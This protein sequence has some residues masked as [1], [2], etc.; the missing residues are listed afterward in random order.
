MAQ[1]KGLKRSSRRTTDAGRF[2]FSIPDFWMDFTIRTSRLDNRYWIVYFK[3]L[4]SPS[5]T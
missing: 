5:S 1:E 3:L 2:L 4:A